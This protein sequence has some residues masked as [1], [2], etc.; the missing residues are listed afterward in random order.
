MIPGDA[1]R[2]SARSGRIIDDGEIV[3]TG[4]PLGTAKRDFGQ[5]VD[6]DDRQIARK[7][8]TGLQKQVA[9]RNDSA[10]ASIGDDQAVSLNRRFRRKRDISAACR[11]DT[12]NRSRV[13]HIGRQQDG[14][15]P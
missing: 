1:L 6:V 11:K 7:R 13:S 14:N 4:L 12:K 10:S 5:S 2:L 9:A 3:G 15:R 8:A